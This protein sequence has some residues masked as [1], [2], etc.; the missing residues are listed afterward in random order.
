M[1]IP[2][3]SVAAT[4]TKANGVPKL[5]VGFLV[6]VEFDRELDAARIHEEMGGLGRI[7]GIG[8]ALRLEPFTPMLADRGLKGRCVAAILVPR[9]ARDGMLWIALVLSVFNGCRRGGYKAIMLDEVASALWCAAEVDVYRQLAKTLK[10]KYRCIHSDSVVSGEGEKLC[11]P[12]SESLRWLKDMRTSGVVDDRG[13]F[14]E[15]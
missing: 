14:R 12:E 3:S 8:N 2:G 11:I 10:E 1:L 6:V 7:C 5:A 13:C 9:R 4:L 15:L